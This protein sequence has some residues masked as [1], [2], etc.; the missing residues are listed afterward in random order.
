LGSSKRQV[1]IKTHDDDIR[2]DPIL[3]I[4]AGWRI[5]KFWLPFIVNFVASIITGVVGL[6]LKSDTR[7]AG[8]GLAVGIPLSLFLVRKFVI[9]YNERI[10]RE[11]GPSGMQFP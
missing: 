10:A 8:L 3:S 5:Q 7:Y 4:Y 6:H 1:N 9:E 11:T 2:L